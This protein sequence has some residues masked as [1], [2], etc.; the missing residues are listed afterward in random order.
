MRVGASERGLGTLCRLVGYTRQAYYQQKVRMEGEVLRSELLL[1]E[2]AKLRRPQPHSGVRKLYSL[3]TEF[4]SEHGITLGRDA[5]F[6]LMRDEGLL[7]RKRKP[8]KP[9][10]TF[11]CL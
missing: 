10:T 9:R 6:R 7:V 3:T 4:R 2:V 1:G 5:F 11:S 8:R